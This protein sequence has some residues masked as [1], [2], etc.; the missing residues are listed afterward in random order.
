M[1]QIRSAKPLTPTAGASQKSRQVVRQRLVKE[2]RESVDLV[3]ARSAL[4]FG[5]GQA[6]GAAEVNFMQLQEV[7]KMMGFMGGAYPDQEK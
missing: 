2:L 3:V 6:G 7:L 5:G 4:L 1:E